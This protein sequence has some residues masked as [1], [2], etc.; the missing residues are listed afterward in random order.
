MQDKEKVCCPS[1][2]A[3]S[4]VTKRDFLRYSTG[5]AFAAGAAVSFAP[6]KAKAA[7]PAS[8]MLK[9]AAQHFVV[10][11]DELVIRKADLLSFDEI[12]G[13]L[14]SLRSHPFVEQSKFD[15]TS[16]MRVKTD[17]GIYFVGGVN[18]ENI[19]LT[20][21]S[22]SEE[23]ALSAAVTAF[24]ERIDVLEGWVMG[25]A[26]GAEKSDLACYPCGECRQRLAQYTAPEAKFHIVSLDGELK[27]TKTRAELLPNAFSFRDFSSEESAAL[28]AVK[29]PKKD[30]APKT[31]LFAEPKEPLSQDAIRDW[32]DELQSDVRVS[33]TDRRL[34]FR[35]SNGAYVAGVKMDNAA[36]PS[37]TTAVQSAIAIMNA[38]YGVQKIE[39]IWTSIVYRD[40]KRNE[41]QASVFPPISG[42]ALQVLYQFA[43]NDKIPVNI[44]AI[45]GQS[46]SISLHNLIGSPP[47]FSQKTP[48]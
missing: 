32:M 41:Q 35:L 25:A 19:E 23:G 26:R 2:D 11:N 8:D 36:Y 1:H 29:L 28:A 4:G 44:Y 48:N 14:K 6:I 47:I 17:E 27:D 13:W 12:Y 3:Q 18:V 24:G 22:C 16:V 10:R 20:V 21:G 42:A 5:L 40:A 15:V 46:R 43:A 45:N 37:S 7:T 34:V 30:R 38:R 31:R 39:E 9:A 33:G